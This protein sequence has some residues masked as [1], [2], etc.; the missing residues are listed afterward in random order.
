MDW[1]FRIS[2]IGR[3]AA[4][5]LAQGLRRR[6]RGDAALR[7][8]RAGADGFAPRQPERV[9]Y[10]DSFFLRGPRSLWLRKS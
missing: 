10:G 7:L 8:A 2:Y 1:H 5:P 3:A 9:D 4:Q 6:G